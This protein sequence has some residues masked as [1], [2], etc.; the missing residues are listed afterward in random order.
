MTSDGK[1]PLIRYVVYHGRHHAE[2]SGYDRVADYG[3]TQFPG[4]KTIRAKPFPRSILRDRIM[5]RIAD[6][7]ISYDR[8][9]IATEVKTFASMLGNRDCIYHF[10]YGEHTYH[11]LGFFNNL[12]NNRLVVTFHHPPSTLK[13]AVMIDWHLRQLSGIICVGKS[14]I[15]FFAKII[16]RDRVF[17]A[18]LGVDVEYYIPPKV[19]KNRRANMCLFVGRHLRDLPALRGIVEI[20]SLHR[21]D[22]QFIAVISSDH[23]GYLGIHPSLKL[24]SNVSETDLLDLYKRATILV[25]PLLDATANNSLLEGL[26]CGLP[27]IVTDVGSII[28]YVNDECAVLVPPHASKKFAYTILDLLEDTERRQYLSEMA[29]KQALKFAWSEVVRQLRPIYKTISQYSN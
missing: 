20:V 18:P 28:D 2:H 9:S 10:L 4:S 15:E 8:E 5:W 11:Y 17:F 14:Q 22:V 13:N 23:S 26:S 6:G 24:L 3:L 21:P 27:T 29:R 7:V 19:F 12:R 16:G 25:L 1:D